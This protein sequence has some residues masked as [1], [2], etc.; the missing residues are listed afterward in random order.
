MVGLDSADNVFV[1]RNIPDLD[2]IL[3]ALNDTKAKCATVIGA[4]FIGLE[5]A[6]N[7]VKKGLQVTIVEKAP[8]VCQR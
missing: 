1:L 2:K 4:G 7:L 5:M 8:H 6:E 3:N